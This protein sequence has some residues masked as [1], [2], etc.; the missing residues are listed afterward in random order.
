MCTSDLC[1]RTTGKGARAWNCMYEAYG[2]APSSESSRRATL[3]EMHR[4][5]CGL[6][7]PLV[8]KD[9]ECASKRYEVVERI[10]LS[11]SDFYYEFRKDFRCEITV[12]P[13]QR[14]LKHKQLYHL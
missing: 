12:L 1:D 2:A 3:R 13:C 10:G 14:I 9:S 11:V 8:I 4:I 6:W 7:F 5:S